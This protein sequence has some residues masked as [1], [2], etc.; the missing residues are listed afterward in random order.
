MP[1]GFVD[2]DEDIEILKQLKVKAYRFSICL[3]RVI[4]KNGEVFEPRVMSNIRESAKRKEFLEQKLEK[5]MARYMSLSED[6]EESEG[7]N[8][9]IQG[10]IYPGCR[11]I[12]SNVMYF[13]KS[14]VSHSKFIR[15]GADVKITAI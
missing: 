15:D 14:D 7:G 1:G 12:I 10:T 6:M 3:T 2:I 5:D 13:V 8:I 4:N 11:I 9:V